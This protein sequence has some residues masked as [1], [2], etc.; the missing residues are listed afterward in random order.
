MAMT[1]N[2]QKRILCGVI[3]MSL[4]ILVFCGAYAYAQEKISPLSDYQ[5]KRDFAQYETIKKEADAQKRA[6]L[7][8][9]YL[10]ERPISRV[11][12]YVVNDYIECVKQIA[13]TD[14][15]KMTSMIESIW[16]LVPTEKTLQAAEIPTGVEEFQ[17][18]QLLPTQRTIL[19]ALT[20]AYY[21]SKNYVKAAELAEKTYQLAPDKAL[22]PP[23]LQIYSQAQNVDKILEYGQKILAEYPMDQP[24]G[25]STA[26]TLAQVYI[27]KQDAKN[28]TELLSKVMEVYGDKVPPGLQEAQWN[29][30]RAFAYGIIGQ[31]IYATKD[32]PKALEVFEKVTKF[33][34]KREDVHYFMGMCKWQTKDP[35]GAMDSFAKCMVLKG[36][37]AA[38]AQKYLEDLYKARNKDSLDGIDKILAKA[39]SELGI[40]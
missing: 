11:L 20:A 25:Y 27:Q 39:K 33:D 10:K 29:P 9:A 2:A 18:D 32:Y 40:N 37:Y 30:T 38:R 35:E 5:Y 36:N 26:L 34:P 21:Q 12:L 3:A 31:G 19:S 16:P 23:L 13:K 14:L 24:Q 8:A 17:K 7:L 22:L 4:A 15:A 1:G 6:D 28:A